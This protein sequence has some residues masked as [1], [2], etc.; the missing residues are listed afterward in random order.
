VPKELWD[1]VQARLKER[2]AAYLRQT[3]GRFYGRPESSRESRYLFSG[4]L[5]CSQCGSAMVVS[6]KS[7]HPVESLY[8]CSY[9]SR[10]PTVCSNGVGV[11]VDDLDSALLDGIRRLTRALTYS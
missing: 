3:G 9:P 4:F 1:A 10:G 2:A 5:Q 6:A 8:K 7:Y 11:S